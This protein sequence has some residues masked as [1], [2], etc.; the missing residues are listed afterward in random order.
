MVCGVLPHVDLRIQ[1]LIQL[2]QRF[3]E[4]QTVAVEQILM[5]FLLLGEHVQQGG[6]RF[7]HIDVQAHALHLAEGNGLQPGSACECGSVRAEW[8]C[9]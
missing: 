4:G 8:F 9:E 1:A 2:G 7:A 5:L 6:M 3:G